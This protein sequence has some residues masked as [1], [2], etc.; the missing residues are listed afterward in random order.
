[1]RFGGKRRRP[2]HG[3][4]TRASHLRGLRELDEQAWRE[5]YEKYR[6][7][8]DGIGTKYGL[9]ASEREE[10]MQEV[11]RICC[12]RLQTYVYDPEKARFRT[13]L[14][15]IAANLSLTLRRRRPKPLPPPPD[16]YGVIPG[17]DPE[18]MRQYEE[19]LLDQCLNALK[20]TVD[21]MTFLTFTLL[22][23]EERPV[24]EVARVT[25]KTA[26][27]IYSIK[28]RCMKKLRGLIAHL[29][30]EGGTPPGSTW[31]GE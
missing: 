3:Y 10:L 25:G 12:R 9:T 31:R 18:F 15:R 7:M 30:L 6:A 21:S 13:F 22:V 19:F 27:A 29:D 11:A 24:P 17:L 8:I 5:F 14:F 2:A 26:G 23:L 4:T 20:N 28:H 16:D 1:M